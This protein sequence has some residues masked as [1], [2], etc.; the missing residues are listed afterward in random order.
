M[1]LEKLIMVRWL[2]VR[3][4]I[5]AWFCPAAWWPDTLLKEVKVV[6]LL[7]RM[8]VCPVAASWGWWGGLAPSGH[9]VSGV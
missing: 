3:V 5:R 4:I 9:R 1:L 6:L 7:K 2:C 8:P